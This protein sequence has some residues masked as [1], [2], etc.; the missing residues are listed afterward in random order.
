MTD[1]S[2]MQLLIQADVDGE[3]DAAAAAGVVAHMAG[4]AACAALYS[5]LLA[6]SGEVRGIE[7]VEAPAGL[8]AVVLDQVR[9]GGEARRSSWIGARWFGVG[10]GWSFGAGLAVA[11][12]AAMLWLPRLERGRADLVGEVV[13]GHVRALQPGHL[14]DVASS[15]RHTV[16]PW[17][18]GRLDFAPPVP[19]LAG[20][21][22]ELVGGR[23]DYLGGRAVAALA[24]GRRQHVI[25]VFVWPDPAGGE[26]IEGSRNG[27][28]HLRWRTG[29][30]TVW[31]VSDLDMREL[32]EFSAAWRSK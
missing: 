30:I 21:G 16:K 15:D 28:N 10:R 11:G 3:L 1:C 13:A 9:R 18:D 29:E 4:C 19:D 5:R 31:A 22:F 26:P 17:F 24:Y 14:F 7:R 12:L 6:L 32:R 8:R 27:Y 2:E 20:A 23:L 25:D